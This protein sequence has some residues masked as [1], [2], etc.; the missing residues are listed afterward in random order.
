MRR[1]QRIIRRIIKKMVRKHREKNMNMKEEQK[2]R[3]QLQHR[4][5]LKVEE[6]WLSKLKTLKRKRE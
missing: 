3:K 4:K 1:G 6:S 5:S 2:Q